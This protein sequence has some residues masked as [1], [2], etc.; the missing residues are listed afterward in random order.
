M[1]LQTDAADRGSAPLKVTRSVTCCFWIDR[2]SNLTVKRPGAEGSGRDSTSM[3]IGTSSLFDIMDCYFVLDAYVIMITKHVSFGHL[4]T[5]RDAIA[6]PPANAEQ[7][8]AT[9]RKPMFCR[10][11]F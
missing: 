6:L 7:H 2:D 3:S 5:E 11:H 10:P 9:L 4:V 8:N 1:N